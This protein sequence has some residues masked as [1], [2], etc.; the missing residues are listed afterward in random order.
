MIVEEERLG[1]GGTNMVRWLVSCKHKAHSGASVTPNDEQNIRDRLGT[2]R[3]QG[4][5]AFYSTLPSSGLGQTL[6]ALRPNF[7]YLQL[8][9]EAIE[10]KPL[11]SPRGRILAARYTPRTFN[12]WIH[13]SQAA[14][15]A[16]PFSDPQRSTNRFF[17]RAPHDSLE[18]AKAEAAERGA[19]VFAVIFDAEH[20]SHSKLDFSLGYFLEYQTTKRLVDQH[21]VAVVGASNEPSLGALV[22]EN[23]PLENCLWVVITPEGAILRREGVYANPDEGMRRVR[24]VLAQRNG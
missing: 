10:R 22:P 24:E 1:P 13:V 17:L 12:S 14:S 9:S 18:A 6:N 4:F 3:C 15:T 16:S 21:F 8:D 2:H 19:L 20:P 5:I 23:D 7:E 11:D